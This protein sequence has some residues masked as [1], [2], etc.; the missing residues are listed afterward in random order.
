VLGPVAGVANAD[1]TSGLVGYYPLDEGAGD[2]AYD[3][4][5]NEHHG[6]LHNG[7]TWI[8]PGFINGAVNLDGTT[9]TRIELGT[10]NPAE[11]TGQLSL[12]LWIRWAGGGPTYQGLIGKRDTWPEM[13]M[14]QFQLRP[15]AYILVE[16]GDIHI[17]ADTGVMTPFI[18]RWAHVAVTFDGTTARIYLNGEVIKSG[19]FALQTAADTASMG[20]GCVTGG[21]EGYSGNGEVFLG[22]IDEVYIHNRA[23]S[24]AEIKS[25]AARYSASNPTPA[26]GAVITQTGVALTWTAG[27]Y[28][29]SHHVYLGTSFDEVYNGTPDT[30]KGS[31]P[32][33]AYWAPDLDVGKTYYWRVDEVSPTHPDSPW[34]G[35]VWRFTIPPET[36]WMPDPADGA[37]FIDPNVTLRWSAGTGAFLHHVY[38][39]DDFDR[40]NNADT[41]D[42]TGIYKGPQNLTFDPGPLELEKVYYWRVD[43]VETDMMTTHKGEVW[44]FSTIGPYAGVKAEYYHWTSAVIPPPRSATFSTRVLT[45]IESEIDHHWGADSPDPL[46]NVDQFAGRWTGELEVAFSEPYTFWTLTDDGVRVWLDGELIIDDW[47]DHGD[48]WNSSRPIDLVAGQRYALVME[49]FENAGGATAEL[50]WASPS[51]PRQVIPAGPLQ[52]P[53]KARSPGPAHG[54]TDVK[55]TPTLNWSAGQDAAQHDVYLGTDRDAV[56]NADTSTAGVYRGR[57]ALAATSYVPTESPLAWDTTYYWRIDEVNG[58]DLWKGAVWSFTTANCLIVD[59]FEEYDDYCNRIFYAWKDGW[60]YSADAD[61]GVT[62]STGNGTGSTVGNLS[63]PYAEQTIVHGGTQSMPYEYN[64]TGTGGKARYSEASLEFATPQNW[65]RNNVKALTLW[66][67]GETGNDPETLYVAL[68]DSLGQVRV[69]T[70]P[71]P[72][73]LQIPTWRQWNIA[74]QQFSGVNLASIKKLYIGVGNRNNPQMGGSGKLYFDDIRIY[75]PRCVPS[76]AKPA[77]DIAEPYDCKVG[78]EDVGVL[79]DEWLLETQ[80]QDWEY[81]AA[82]W[83]SRYRTNWATDANSITVR[84]GLAAAGYTILDADQLKTWMDARIADGKLSVVVF[85]RDNAPDTVVESVDATCTLRRYLDAG[86]K[87]VFYADIPF[88]DIAHA[89][90]TWDNPQTAGASD[91]LG[92]DN[93]VVLWDSNTQT[94]LT[95]AGIRWGLTQTWASVRPIAATTDVTVL[96]TD[97]A[98]NAAAWV[99]HYLPRDT[100]RGFVRLWDRTG[101]PPVEDIIRVAESKGPLAANLYQDAVVDFKD[102]AVLADSWLD[103]LWWP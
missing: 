24:Q 19:A 66:F 4:S 75:P 80:L 71:D 102:F 70:H 40:V 14:F 38:F 44:S 23:L 87:I 48:T 103:E 30:D 73:A 86:G 29:D 89:D 83:D 42:T 62:A 77:A 49:W 84:D 32:W 10:W 28:A 96:A 74:L 57:Q 31:T 63:A 59:D 85:C 33:A 51:M 61:C 35:P 47:N 27:T 7:V 53:L 58:V 67:H 5:G 69:A 64:N 3:M 68:E 100:A 54:A 60:G 1:I 98:G 26:D 18:G 13:T 39:G 92:F 37:K 76:M 95:A 93:T 82:Y 11:G 8:S 34:R 9:N 65:T 2:T 43:E 72:E 56:A 41:S 36:A 45:R 50:D 6:T 16:T 97:A 99:R 25:L 79:A 91:I 15:E 90:G 88:W 20:I 46:V 55:Q 101:R 81:R 52:L 94:T 12:A 78:Y 17:Y 21:G 22:D